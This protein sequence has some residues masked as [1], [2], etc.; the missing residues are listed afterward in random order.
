MGSV[1]RK[2]L[3]LCVMYYVTLRMRYGNDVTIRNHWRGSTHAPG[4]S[5]FIS[6]FSLPSCRERN[7]PNSREETENGAVTVRRENLRVE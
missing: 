7:M 6:I 2:S 3:L 4:G 1:E 5:C